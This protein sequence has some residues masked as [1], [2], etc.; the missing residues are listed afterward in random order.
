[1][2]REERRRQGRKRIVGMYGRGE[3]TKLLRS[4]GANPKAEPR[5]GICISCGNT[6]QPGEDHSVCDKC[7]PPDMLHLKETDPH[8]GPKYTAVDL[9]TG[10]V[11]EIP[12][13]F[14]HL[15]DPEKEAP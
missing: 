4:L 9:D 3:E 8:G 6:L 11:R 12:D 1:M 7:F 14:E 13:P 15:E 10:D 5:S 2:N